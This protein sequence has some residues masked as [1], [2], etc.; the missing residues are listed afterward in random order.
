M[1]DRLRALLD[2]VVLSLDDSNLDGSTLAR[3]AHFS[4]DHLDRLV[5]AATGESPIA[6][7]R[8]LL[9]ERAAWQLRVGACSAGE[10]ARAADYRSLAAFSRA[11]I[12]A[13]GPTPSAFAASDRAIRRRARPRPGLRRCAPTRGRRRPARARRPRR[14]LARGPA[15]A[16]G[17][18]G[19][20]MRRTGLTRLSG[21][22]GVYGDAAG[23]EMLAMARSPGLRSCRAPDQGRTCTRRGLRHRPRNPRPG[24][25]GRYRGRPGPAGSCA[26]LRRRRR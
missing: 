5:A 8:R 22:L 23:T 4:R 26:V 21:G 14:P 1:E 11:F 24:G 19:E 7:R 10:A 17:D 20:L 25:A 18:Y 15:G 6:L 3:R 2:L 9:L 13:Y 12:R 16:Y